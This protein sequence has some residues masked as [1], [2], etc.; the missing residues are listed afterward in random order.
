MWRWH[1]FSMVAARFSPPVTKIAVYRFQ[2]SRVFMNPQIKFQRTACGV[3]ERMKATN[4]K[5][6]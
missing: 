5:A 3:S 2:D 6:A 4:V 1:G